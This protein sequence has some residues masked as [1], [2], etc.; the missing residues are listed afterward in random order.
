MISECI[1]RHNHS[2]DWENCKILN[3]EPNYKIIISETIHIKEQKNGLNLNTDTEFLDECY[4]S[5]LDR[6]VE[7][8]L[9]KR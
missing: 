2:F 7:T 9:K 6:L 5:I 3:V 8:Y 4:F 1:L